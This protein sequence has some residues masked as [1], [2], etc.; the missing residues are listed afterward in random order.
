VV[1]ERRHAFEEIGWRVVEDR[2]ENV[3]IPERHFG[4]L[5]NSQVMAID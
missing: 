2:F 3:V 5:W 4:D 1:G